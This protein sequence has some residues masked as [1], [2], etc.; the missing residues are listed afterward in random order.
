M[1][2]TLIVEVVWCNKPGLWQQRG[3]TKNQWRG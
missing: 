1:V 3:K 2:V